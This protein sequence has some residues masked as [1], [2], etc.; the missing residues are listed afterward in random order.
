MNEFIRDEWTTTADNKQICLNPTIP[1]LIRYK[2]GIFINCNGIL[3]DHILLKELEEYKKIIT[4]KKK[5][6]ILYLSIN[7]Q[8]F[9]QF[10][11]DLLFVD[12]NIETF[13]LTS[14]SK[15]DLIIDF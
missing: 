6:K 5:I 8:I 3:I 4:E 13:D 10:N 11:D 7:K 9:T 14:K 1:N 2:I 15:S 12:S